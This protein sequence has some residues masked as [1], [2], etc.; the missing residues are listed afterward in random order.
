[1]E[2]LAQRSGTS[3]RFRN[4]MAGTGPVI[5]SRVTTQKQGF[6][7]VRKISILNAQNNENIKERQSFDVNIKGCLSSGTLY[8]ILIKTN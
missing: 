1:M 7:T 3:A 6:D 4:T 2:A 8:G 5:S